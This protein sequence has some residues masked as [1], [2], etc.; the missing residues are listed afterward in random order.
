MTCE[1][2]ARVRE[3]PEQIAKGCATP[4]SRVGTHLK[5]DLE[6]LQLGHTRVVNVQVRDQTIVHRLETALQATVAQVEDFPAKGFVRREPVLAVNEKMRQL[7]TTHHHEEV[8]SARTPN[9]PMLRMQFLD[10]SAQ[11]AHPAEGARPAERLELFPVVA[12]VRRDEP[13]TQVA[14]QAEH[15]REEV[16]QPQPVVH[17]HV[18]ERVRRRDSRHGADFGRERLLEVGRKVRVVR[19]EVVSAVVLRRE[20]GKERFCCGSA[21]RV[22]SYRPLSLRLGTRRKLVTLPE[23]ELGQIRAVMRLC[24]DRLRLRLGVT[25][26]NGACVRVSLHKRFSPC[27]SQDVLEF[28]RIDVVVKVRSDDTV[29]LASQQGRVDLVHVS[30]GVGVFGLVQHAG[31][32]RVEIK[33]VAFVSPDCGHDAEG[34][35]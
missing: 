29:K 7:S 26:Y 32:G 10:E 23:Q 19:L 11:A 25:V 16:R 1:G 13:L 22:V 31:Q 6:F 8:P 20:E 17:R 5:F 28:A 27:P 14:L 4:P 24:V 9:A 12:L 15:A 2:T 33:L 34:A 30:S 18:V 21:E 35:V 3:R